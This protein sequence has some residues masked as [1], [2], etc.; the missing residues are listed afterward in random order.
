MTSQDTYL[1]P[2]LKTSNLITPI[3]IGKSTAA[4]NNSDLIVMSDRNLIDRLD[5]ILALQIKKVIIFGTPKLHDPSGS[6]AWNSKGIVQNTIRTIQSNFD[7]KI[8]T[9]AD[10]CVC[11]Y[12]LSGHCGIV[13]Q[14]SQVD[15]HK[16]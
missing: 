16:T 15:N 14:D 12:N 5:K 6:Q 10:V 2:L 4:S 7:K 8:E 11:Q 3:I 9:I 13:N 1:N